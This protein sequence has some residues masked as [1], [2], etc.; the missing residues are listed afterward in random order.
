MGGFS[1]IY[2]HID[3]FL[4]VLVRISAFIAVSP[5]FGRKGIPA[6]TK[7]GFSL[8]LSAI[9]MLGFDTL[10]D[11][12][13]IEDA[14]YIMLVV[15]EALIGIAVSFITVIFFSIFYAAGQLA[16]M[17]MGFSVG[18]VYD[19]Q[20][21]TEVPLVGNFLYA[22][23]MLTFIVLN[24]VPK[25]V[26][27]IYSMYDSIPITGGSFTDTCYEVFYSAFS[28]TYAYAVKLI[29]PLILLM[30]ITEFLLGVI[31]KFM[32]QMNVFV[33]GIP[34][35]IGMSLLLLNFLVGPAFQFLDTY[36]NNMFES[37]MMLIR[38]MG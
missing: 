24:G 35:K 3:V 36:F 37:A 17:Q 21:Q 28:F 18:G 2:T 34:V 12:S 14:A 11:L 20:M 16:D 30:L 27:L 7:V 10:P 31:I 13:G 29:L 32:P 4:L 15:K 38:S 33:I 8:I 26:F 1:V 25:L 22:M 9:I 23:G 5:V 6:T 19:V